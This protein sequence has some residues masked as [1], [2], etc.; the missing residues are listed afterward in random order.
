MHPC[1]QL[2]SP[3]VSFIHSPAPAPPG[4]PSLPLPGAAC[5]RRLQPPAPTADLSRRRSGPPSNARIAG[6]G[7]LSHFITRLGMNATL[8]RETKPETRRWGGAV[9]R[10]MKERRSDGRLS[11]VL[12][13]DAAFPPE[14]TWPPPHSPS[15]LPSPRK[16][17]PSGLP[18]RGPGCHFACSHFLFPGVSCSNSRRWCPSP[19]PLPVC[20]GSQREH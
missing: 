14:V 12:V 1:L 15:P 18:P 19:Y 8:L 6:S 7:F 3:T 9:R 20:C 10:T 11:S 2:G 16:T 5:Y 17:E 13:P 4:P